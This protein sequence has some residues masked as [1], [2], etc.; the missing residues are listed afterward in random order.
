MGVHDGRVLSITKIVD[1]GPDSARMNLALIAEGFRPAEQASFNKL[2]GDF[3]TALQSEDWYATAGKAINVHRLNVESEESGADEPATCPDGATGSGTMVKTYFDAQFC[4]G[5]IWRCLS[6]DQSLV[7]N[8]LDTWLPTWNVGIVMV[9]TIYHGGCATGN[10]S[11]T[12]VRAGW[13]NTALHEL[14]HNFGLADEYHYWY[15]CSSGET[16]HNN[17]PASEPKAA[18]ITTDTNQATL[19]WRHLL[20]PGVRFPTMEN[21]DCSECDNR[22][23]VIPDDSA[24]GLFEGAGYFHCGL[25]RPAYRCRMRTSNAP[26]C[27]VCAEAIVRWLSAYT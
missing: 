6:G 22:P 9:N 13:E 25:Y 4:N 17:A 27:R 3:V 8:T 2:C 20:T 19:K 10:V 1:N 23:N 12:S 21:P 7:R 5:G 11:F 16:D 24:I 18:N 14:G 15:G 26:F